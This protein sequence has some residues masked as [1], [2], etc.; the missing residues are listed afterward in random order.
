M[1]I[2]LIA[3]SSLNLMERSYILKGSQKDI[4]SFPSRLALSE[5][6]PG[7]LFPDSSMLTPHLYHI[8]LLNQAALFKQQINPYPHS[9]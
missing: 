2:R 1:P 8:S 7:M 5:M 9:C 4:Q 6:F 3:C